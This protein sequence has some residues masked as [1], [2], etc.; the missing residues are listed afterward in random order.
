MRRGLGERVGKV[1]FNEIC[2]KTEFILFSTGSS[3]GPNDVEIDDL[4]YPFVCDSNKEEAQT[5]RPDCLFQILLIIYS[6]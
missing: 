6:D 3:C 1:V 4:R 5:L 2:L